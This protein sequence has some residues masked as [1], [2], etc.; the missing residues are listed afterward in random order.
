MSEEM[1]VDE[2]VDPELVATSTLVSK[3]V[4]TFH[5]ATPKEEIPRCLLYINAFQNYVI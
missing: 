5:A 4:T 2:H 1:Y 3:L